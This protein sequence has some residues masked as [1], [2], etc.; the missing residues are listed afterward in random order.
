MGCL[1]SA[2]Q[3]RVTTQ[4]ECRL[5]DY[6]DSVVAHSVDQASPDR[7][8][9]FRA[10]QHAVPLRLHARLHTRAP[11]APPAAA[12]AASSGVRSS[13]NMSNRLGAAACCCCCCVGGCVGCVAV[14]VPFSDVSSG[15]SSASSS[16]RHARLFSCTDGCGECGSL[17]VWE[18]ES[19]GA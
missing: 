19:M 15:S 11:A 10:R 5:G 1:H 8:P 18:P 2:T 9:L 4:I 6:T 14:A 16:L 3:V 13:P 7:H 17:R 12:A